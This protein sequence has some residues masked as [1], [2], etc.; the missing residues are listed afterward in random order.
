MSKRDGSSPE[1][2]DATAYWQQR[3]AANP[4]LKGTG[5][6]FMPEGWQRW[7][8]RAKETAYRD[9]LARN[10]VT[11]DGARVLDFGCGTGFF[12]DLWQRAGARAIAGI[13]IVPEA[14]AGLSAA[15]P[16]RTYLCADLG[17]DV[18]ALTALGKF[19]VVT[20]I[21]VLYHVVDDALVERILDALLASVDKRGVFV[22][23]DALDDSRPAQHVRF[24]DADWWER[25]LSNRGFRIRGREPVA[26]VHNRP[27][28][29]ARRF[30]GPVGAAQF[31]ADR[32]LKRI[33]PGRANNWAVLASA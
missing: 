32:L 26:I 17:S 19:D 27:N 1:R 29:L 20:A 28:P 2:F 25:T 9:L 33:I 22:F 7:L 8:Y 13:D 18:A 14:I 23:S 31:Y 3:L 5:T 15:H 11:I 16:E 4:G 12:E 30:P 10:H 21:D 6:S 24:R